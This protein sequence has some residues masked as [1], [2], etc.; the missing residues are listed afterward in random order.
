MSRKTAS[1]FSMST[2][3]QACFL[4]AMGN[5]ACLTQELLHEGREGE[6]GASHQSNDHQHV[7]DPD[8]YVLSPIGMGVP[9]HFHPRQNSDH[10]VQFLTGMDESFGYDIRYSLRGYKYH[11]L[12][13]LAP[14]KDEDF[15]LA[16]L[17][18]LDKVA[19]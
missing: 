11:D 7:P 17:F 15:Q 16:Q 18:G 13:S 12:P 1:F 9:K 10:S 4:P 19:A 5:Q 14:Y 8:L 3:R 6:H 2:Y